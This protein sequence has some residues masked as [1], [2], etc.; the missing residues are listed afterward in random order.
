ML[1]SEGTKSEYGDRKIM[2]LIEALEG[3]RDYAFIVLLKTK[4][5]IR[6]ELLRILNIERVLIQEWVN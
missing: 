1:I 4:E 2:T 5:Y 6:P 3:M